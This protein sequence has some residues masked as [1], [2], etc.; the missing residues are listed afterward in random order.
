MSS[1]G[2]MHTRES[3]GARAKS[4]H[5]ALSFARGAKKEYECLTVAEPPNY[6][7]PPVLVI[8]LK[9][10]NHCTSVPQILRSLSGVL[11]KPES[12]TIFRAE[13]HYRGI[14]VLQQFI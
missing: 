8:V 5:L 4:L 2:A 6:Y 10:S 11:G 9:T 13:S 14:T 7:G 1:R 3:R 12:S